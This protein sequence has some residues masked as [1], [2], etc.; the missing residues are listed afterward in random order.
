M[1]GLLVYYT[2]PYKYWFAKFLSIARPGSENARTAYGGSV[3]IKPTTLKTIIKTLHQ[4][5]CLEEVK[6]PLNN[7]AATAMC[8]YDARQQELVV[9]PNGPGWGPVSFVI[10]SDKLSFSKDI[11]GAPDLEKLKIEVRKDAI[12]AGT[13]I[14]E[15]SW[16]MESVKYPW[17][18]IY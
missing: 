13:E 16:N 7:N 14:I 2:I 12:F 1:S 6:W 4:K 18:A 11:K 15:N 5:N 3:K 10:T 9:Y 17:Y 8:R